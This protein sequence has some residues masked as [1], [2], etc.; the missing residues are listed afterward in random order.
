ECDLYLACDSLVGADPV[1]LRVADPVRTIAVVST[2]RVPTGAMIADPGVSFPGQPAIRASIDGAV[3]RACY[4]DAQGLSGA[5]FGDDQFANILQLGAAY[6]AGAIRLS[7]Q[8]IERAIEANGTA[9]TAN[10]Q[11]FRR[12]RQAVADPAALERALAGQSPLIGQHRGD[13]PAGTSP[14][15]GQPAPATSLAAARVRALV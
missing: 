4:L 3:A 8:A 9:V 5:L 12:G 7:A 2:A 6:Q 15:T 1:N 13:H 14:A 10:I 11:A